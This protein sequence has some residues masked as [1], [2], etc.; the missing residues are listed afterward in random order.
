LDNNY[1]IALYGLGHI[2]LPTASLLAK[3]GFK[4]T[5]VDI[6][7]EIVDKI[8]AG[9][10]PIIEPGLNE[11]VKEVVANKLLLASTDGVKAAKNANIMIVVVPTPVDQN[12]CSDLSAII[13]AT[14]TI[15][16]G[17]D[18]ED[19]VIIEST[20]PPSTCENIVIPILENSGLTGGIDFGI[21]YTP[22]RALPHNTL[23]EM[24]HNAR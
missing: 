12:N 7:N 11:L 1:K 19:L 23:Y 14:Q 21:A 3:N 18:K 4:V 15:S 9:I 24:T 10:S 8:N 2:G 22:E 17:L 6:N 16:E 13:A 5:G 20:V